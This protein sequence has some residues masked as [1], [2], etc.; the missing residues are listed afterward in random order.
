MGTDPNQS[1]D[2]VDGSENLLCQGRGFDR[3]LLQNID[4]I[5]VEG[6]GLAAS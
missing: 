4:S 2:G 1:Q 6:P 5:V 3:I